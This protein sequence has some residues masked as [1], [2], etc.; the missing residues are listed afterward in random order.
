[1]ALAEARAKAW[2]SRVAELRGPQ[3]DAANCGVK[4]VDGYDIGA[5]ALDPEEPEG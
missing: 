1:V 4:P 5:N 3:A 2:N